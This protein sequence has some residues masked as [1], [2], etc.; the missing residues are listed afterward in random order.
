[1]AQREMEFT[2]IRGS[3]IEGRLHD[4]AEPGDTSQY[5]SI[6]RS[7]LAD[8]RWHPDRW[9]EFKITDGSKEVHANGG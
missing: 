8:E 1:M 9:H 7:W 2:V 5:R 4:V 3:S 6:L